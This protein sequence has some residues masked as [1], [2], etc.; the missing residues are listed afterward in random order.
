M[1]FARRQAYYFTAAVTFSQVRSVRGRYGITQSFERWDACLS[2]IVFGLSPNDAQKQFETWLQTTPE[3]ENPREAVIRKVTAT[4]FV[5]RFLAE[6]G[7]SMW[8]W[9]KIP[10]Q[11]ECAME[12]VPVDDFE[13]GYW[14]DVNEVVRPDKLSFSIRTLESDVP[15]N[16]R[17]GLNWTGEKQFFFFFSILTPPPPPANRIEEPEVE[18]P[19]LVEPIVGDSEDSNVISSGEISAAF[20][21]AFNKE[22]VAVIQAR[23]SV[24]AAWLWR[25]YA[26]NT[27]LMANQIRIDPWP[28]MLGLPDA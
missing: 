5:D 21:D 23:N 3:G 9:S 18:N 14:V 17:S 10:K 22:A 15:E 28:G 24:V 16:V 27:N 11:V 19:D 1:E 6:S 25:R 26:V 4:Q 8:D 13:Q 20:P 12:S 7:N 2:Q